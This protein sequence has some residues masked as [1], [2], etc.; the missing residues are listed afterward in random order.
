[1]R[2]TTQDSS[3]ARWEFYSHTTA[4]VITAGTFYY[5]DGKLKRKFV[6]DFDENENRAKGKVL[7]PSG[8]VFEG[9]FANDQIVFGRFKYVDKSGSE[10]YHGNF[11][12]GH[13]SGRGSYL[14]ANGNM[15]VG[16]WADNEQNGQGTLTRPNGVVMEGIWKDGD[17]SKATVKYRNG[18][19][20]HGDLKEDVRRHGSGVYRYKSSGD[21]YVGEWEEGKQAGEGTMVYAS[22]PF[23]MFY[24]PSTFTLIHF[25]W[26]T[27]QDMKENGRG[28]IGMA[29]AR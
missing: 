7:F 2:G 14:F 26:Q 4:H 10:Y 23:Q 20:Y 11:K 29:R 12:G 5:N 18:D 16:E 15:Y 22:K 19:V 21:V 24:F 13:R 3:T 8:S 27:V 1:M 6:G 28:A 9:E 17:L 25:S